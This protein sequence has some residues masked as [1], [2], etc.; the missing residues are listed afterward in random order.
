M[1]NQEKNNF[2]CNECNKEFDTYKG[3]LNHKRSHN[4]NNTISVQY[5]TCEC[6]NRTISIGNFDKH[7]C[8]KKQQTFSISDDC[9]ISRIR[10]AR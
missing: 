8:D 4:E 7:K 3:L 10:K 9:K 6:C 1:K 2:I 5:K